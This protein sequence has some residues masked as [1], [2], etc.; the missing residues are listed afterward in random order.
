MERM[1]PLE[2]QSKKAQK[3]FYKSK[4]NMWDINPITRKSKGSHDY[5][6]RK[7]EMRGI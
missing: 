1:I 2:K 4:R 5:K 7:E 3:E 6:K